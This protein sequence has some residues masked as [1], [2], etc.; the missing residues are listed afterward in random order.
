MTQLV[1]RE[2]G[3]K[4]TSRANLKLT[5]G[6]LQCGATQRINAHQEGRQNGKVSSEIGLVHP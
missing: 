5:E 1:T 4:A 3:A 2:V 6:L